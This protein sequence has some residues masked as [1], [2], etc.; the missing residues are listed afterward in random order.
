M[1]V[2]F[3]VLIVGSLGVFLARES[4]D[5]SAI[6][7]HAREVQQ[8]LAGALQHLTS[9]EASQ[10]GFLLSNGEEFLEPYRASSADATQALARLRVL[11]AENDRQTRALTALNQAVSARLASLEARIEDRRAGIELSVDSLR[12]GVQQTGNVRSLVQSMSAAEASLVTAREN[13]AT[14][15][16]LIVVAVI[17]SGGLLA[18]GLL[19]IVGNS[20][21]RDGLEHDAA[22]QRLEEQRAELDTQSQAIA[23][24]QARIQQ[25][26]EASQLV[27]NDLTATRNDLTRI[28]EIAN[29]EHDD[30]ILQ[31]NRADLAEARNRLMSESIP[32]QVWT[33]AAD[34][35]LEFVNQHVAEYF[36]RSGEEILGEG[37]L[38]VMHPD[39]VSPAVERWTH[40]LATGEPYDAEFRFRSKD[41]AW[42]WHRARAFAERDDDGAIVSWL[43]TNLDVDAE[44]R[45]SGSSGTL[46][47]SLARA[48]AELDQLV[49][50]ASQDLK[51]PLRGIGN[52]AEWIEEEIG[53]GMPAGAKEKMALLRGRV[54]RVEALL[55]GMLEYARAGQV[56]TP[57]TTVDTGALVHEMVAALRLPESVH[58]E[59]ATPL[60]NVTSERIPLQQVFVNVLA[61][62]LKYS[63]KPDAQ[64][65][66]S[67]TAQGEFA[68]FEVSGNG[69]GIAAENH[70]RVFS[71]FQRLTSR[72]KSEDTGIGL[73]I[74][75]K[76]VEGRGGRVWIES[77]NNAETGTGTIFHFTWPLSHHE[78]E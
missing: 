7:S 40:S 17:V 8:T 57:P 45:E 60:P 48:N 35:Q 15:V 74:V 31:R 46:V 71:V 10:R 66:V 67:G 49:R 44:R 47:R 51:A 22:H 63:G 36:G 70:E 55:D 64:L 68:H 4:R 11:V 77:P 52:L 20:L 58:V 41:G 38:S 24:H 65:H 3:L 18:I 53:P 69:A 26:L 73:A 76:L 5:D 75:K 2:A 16:R 37:W 56:H 12:Q 33:A 30:A 29:R 78:N 50:V 32:V 25:Q 62:A 54:R 43:G 34:G 59:I 28:T 9:A 1:L 23:D 14:R 61:N 21:R 27:N 13:R 39:D 6:V 42:R 72:D 19:V